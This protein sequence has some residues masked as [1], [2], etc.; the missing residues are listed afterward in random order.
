[1]RIFPIVLCVVIRLILILFELKFSVC[2]VQSL[3]CKTCRKEHNCIDFDGIQFSLF[4]PIVFFF[5]QTST[6]VILRALVCVC[7]AIVN[8]SATNCF[9]ENIENS[10]SWG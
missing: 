7:I 2:I 8:M 10:L 3:N 9:V 5:A 6:D 4:I 1:M